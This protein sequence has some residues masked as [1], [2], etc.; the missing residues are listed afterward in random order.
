MS[1]FTTPTVQGMKNGYTST[2]V[3]YGFLYGIILTLSLYALYVYF[4]EPSLL[5]GDKE[6]WKLWIW[7]I[8]SWCILYFMIT[9]GGLHEI[10][11]DG[12]KSQ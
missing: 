10:Y 1:H 4:T 6:L 5:S 2:I 12:T 9:I 8:L 11:C 3:F 7:M